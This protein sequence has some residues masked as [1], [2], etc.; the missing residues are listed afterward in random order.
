MLPSHFNISLQTKKIVEIK[1]Y[2]I[3][4]LNITLCIL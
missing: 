2:L 4:Y 1:Y 3:E